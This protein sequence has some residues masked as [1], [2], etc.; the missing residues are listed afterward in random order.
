M[1]DSAEWAN[2]LLGSEG[3][4]K[5]RSAVAGVERRTSVEIVPMVVRASGSYGHVPWLVFLVTLIVGWFSITML[6]A[7]VHT[8]LWVLDAAAVALA[9]LLSILLSRFDFIK[10]IFTPGTDEVLSVE[11]RA[12]LEFYLARV[13][14]TDTRTGILLFASL[15]EHRA[16]ILADRAITEKLPKETWNDIIAIV[17]SKTK[18][19]DFSGGISAAIEALGARLEAHFPANPQR[20]SQLADHLII[21]N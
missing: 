11:R 18:D 6:A 19:G 16:V 13:E 20:K 5:I 9:A 1:Q 15:L 7:Y 4:E 14:G 17:I 21:K 12:M 10:R 8:P 2:C 3:R